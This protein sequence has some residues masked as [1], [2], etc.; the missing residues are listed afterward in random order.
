MKRG[1]VWAVLLSLVGIGGVWSGLSSVRAA[2]FNSTNFSINGNLGDSAAGSQNSTNYQLVSA[3]GESVAGNSSSKSYLLGQGYVPT[4]ENSMQLITQPGGQVG[5]WSFDENNGSRVYD[6]STTNADGDIT[7]P[8]TWASGKLGTALTFNGTGN[9]VDVGNP[10]ALRVTSGTLQAWIKSSQTTG[11][12]AI[13]GKSD[14][15]YVLLSSNRIAIFDFNTSTT[16]QETAGLIA[17]GAWHH[18]AVT[19]QSGVNNGTTIYRDGI[20]TK[21]CTMTTVNQSS[22]VIIGDDFTHTQKFNGQLDEVKVYNRVL[23]PSEVKAE[24]DAGNAGALGGLSLNAV[25]PG[26]SQTAS[27]DSIIQTSAPS[28]TLAINQNHNLQTGLSGVSSDFSQTFDSFPDGTT[29][30]T[31]NTGFTA[32]S[33]SGGG[34]FTA[35]STSPVHNGFGRMQTTGSSTLSVQD[36][37]GSTSSRYYRF[38]MRMASIP[39]STQTMFNLRDAST[40]TVSSIRVQND[41]TFVL[42]NG[43][44]AVAT[45]TAALG[46][47]QWARI[48]LFYNAAS[49]TQTARLYLGSNYDG[50]IPTETLTGAATNGAT[51]DANYGMVTAQASQTVDLD[52]VATSTA[53]WLGP[54]GGTAIPAVSGSIGSPAAWSE[55]TTKGLGFTLY[56]TN[57][58]AIPGA[59]GSGNNYAALPM[60]GTTFYTRTGYTAGAKDVLSMRLRLDVA[61]NQ[62]SG[63]YTNQMTITGTMTP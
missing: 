35:A 37:Y 6:A 8:A 47:N 25:T 7:G 42:R 2:T 40:N 57:A 13:I 14:N 10:T 22:N 58:T 49:S 31:G 54:S 21:T 48:E 23:S 45:S 55:G 63:D 46:A 33:N 56:S 53:G 26:I 43:N 44:T 52:E 59:W 32:I 16:C 62:E 3:A 28:Y 41:G 29:L 19:F 51:V 38:Y 50:S 5:Y 34:T 60:T 61:T 24:Y 15:Y 4:L 12:Q 27:F 36:D 20:A 9:Y 1:I 18:I 17:D 39:G 30:T 11:T